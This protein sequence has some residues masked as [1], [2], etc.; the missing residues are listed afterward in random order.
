MLLCHSHSIP[1]YDIATYIRTCHDSIAVVPSA[2]TCSDLSID[3]FGWE[4]N[5]YSITFPFKLWWK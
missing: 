1:G 5:K 3:G 4:Q 2:N